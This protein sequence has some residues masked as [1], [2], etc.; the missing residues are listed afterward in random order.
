MLSSAVK[1]DGQSA[2]AIIYILYFG[3]GS[4]E[5]QLKGNYPTTGSGIFTELPVASGDSFKCWHN[6]PGVCPTP[7]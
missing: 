1:S 2:V 7:S 3:G 5:Q 6:L 4:S